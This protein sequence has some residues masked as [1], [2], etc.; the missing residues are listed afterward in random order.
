MITSTANPTVKLIR[1]LR[2]KKERRQSG[3][4]FIE[5]LRIVGD[6]IAGGWQVEVLVYS[7]ERMTSLFGQQTVQSFADSGGSVLE[8]SG[9]VFDSLSLKDGPQGLGAIVQQR[10]QELDAVTVQPGDVWI[11][12]DSVADPGNLGTIIR[13]CDA[14]GAK[15]I[16][17]LDQST[18]PFDPSAV[19][20]SMGALFSCG[21][22]KASFAEFS[23]WK[24]REHIAVV[25]TS[26]RAEQDYHYAD[27]PQQLV[28]LMG[29]ERQGL[30]DDHL[31]ICDQVVSIPMR[32]TGDSLNLAIAT[33]LVAFEVYNHQRDRRA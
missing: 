1:K 20:A 13:T 9:E 11:A 31:Q 33:A 21:L 3:K 24:K 6:A 30:Q 23:R 25:G 4:F 17:L 22:V 14:V 32:G 2:D 18:D 8:V 5:G 28:I 10:W 16:I 12:L 27:Y 19:R 7:P 15:G 29:S 26:D